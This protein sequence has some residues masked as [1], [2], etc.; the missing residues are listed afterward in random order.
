[1]I[2]WLVK[3]WETEKP[4]WVPSATYK[5]QVN[6][7]VMSMGIRPLRQPL[8]WDCRMWLPPSARSNQRILLMAVQSLVGDKLINQKI[9]GR[10][11]LLF[12]DEEPRLPN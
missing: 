10:G 3:E 6:D 12:G 11:V 8:V 5:Q 1:M 7:T 4:F 2:L 9:W